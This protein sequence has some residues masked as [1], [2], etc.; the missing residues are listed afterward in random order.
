MENG[1]LK[2]DHIN[3]SDSSMLLERMSELVGIHEAYLRDLR[4]LTITDR[5]K[6]KAEMRGI[7]Y[8]I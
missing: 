8:L 4:N 6:L 5:N 1:N 7:H 3:L 2:K